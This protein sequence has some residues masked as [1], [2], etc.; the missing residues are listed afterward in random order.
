MSVKFNKIKIEKGYIRFP[1][2]LVFKDA[3]HLFLQFKSGSFRNEVLKLN[4]GVNHLVNNYEFQS[5]N[6]CIYAT[7]GIY[8][9]SS[10]NNKIIIKNDL[11]Y[12]NL[13]ILIQSY[14]SKSDI[15]LRVYLSYLELS[16]TKKNFIEN[17]DINSDIFFK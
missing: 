8:Q 2:T 16:D 5:L 11:N 13:P 14:S 10:N 4:N 7:D 3:K 17:L 9:I 15:L 6:Q 12:S 1:L